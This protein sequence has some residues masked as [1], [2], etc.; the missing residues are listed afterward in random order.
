MSTCWHGKEGFCEVC[1]LII[2]EGHL[3]AVEKNGKNNKKDSEL[4]IDEE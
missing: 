1:Y 2:G 3:K 4:D